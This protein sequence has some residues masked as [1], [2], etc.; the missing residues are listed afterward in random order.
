[1]I[2]KITLKEIAKLA[3]VSTATVSRVINN[4]KHVNEDLR[5]RVLAV[6]KETNY[7]PFVAQ[8][9]SLQQEQQLIG[10]ICPQYSNTVLDDLIVGINKVCKLYGYDTVI[11]LTDGTD[12][13][14]VHYIDLFSNKLDVQGMIFMGNQWGE[15]HLEFTQKNLTPVVLVGQISSIPSIPSVHVDNITASYEAVTYLLQSGHR[16][17][18]MIRGNTGQT[19][20]VDRFKGYEKALSDAGISVN[21]SWVIDS[22]LSIEGGKKAMATILEQDELPTAVFCSTD[23]LAIGAMTY[24]TD[25]GYQ[26]PDDLSVF[27]FDSIDLSKLIRPRLSTIQYSAVEIG[28]TATRNL[29]KLC[30]G[31]SDEIAPHLNVMHDLVIRE[32]TGQRARKTVS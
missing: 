9:M 18:A 17:I 30:K 27:G 16:Q 31:E 28:M 3:D 32:S 13:N 19:V 1:M 8:N 25:H 23:S 11:G 14:E 2:L 24:L 6:L 5:K 22:E 15:G 12:E 10:V 4:S 7:L 21:E 29:I 26:V 20:R